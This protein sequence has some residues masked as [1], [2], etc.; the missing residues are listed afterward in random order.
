MAGVLILVCLPVLGCSSAVAEKQSQASTVPASA[1]QASRSSAPD[2]GPTWQSLDLVRQKAE[3]EP[4]KPPKP[5]P[6]CDD[7]KV[8]VDRSHP[9]PPGYAPED[10]VPL[11]DYGIPTPGGRGLTIRSAAAEPLR[12]LVETADADGEELVVASAFRSYA[13]QQTTHGRLKSI[14]GPRAD[15]MSA[16]PGHS[17]HQ[18]GT[19]VDFTNAAVA[20]Q[21]RPSFGRTGAAEWLWDHATEYGFVLAYPPGKDGTD[22]DFEPWHYR[23][24]GVDNA[25]RLEK[26]GLTLQEFLIREGVSPHC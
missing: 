17:Q 10:L 15:A 3:P 2:P 22:Y 23:Y 11:P 25:D 26:S 19:A 1:A 5:A 6:T 4:Q 21:V 8:L 24:I 7:L 13:D 9:L 16:A 18:L 20:Y 12:S 14:Y